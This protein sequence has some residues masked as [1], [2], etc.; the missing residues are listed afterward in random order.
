MK[1]TFVTSIATY[2]VTIAIICEVKKKLLENY[3]NEKKIDWVWA[4]LIKG[5]TGNSR[6]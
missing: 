6:F 2:N 3:N 4:T 5:N 1:E